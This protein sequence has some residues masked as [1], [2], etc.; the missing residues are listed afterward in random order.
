MV[1]VADKKVELYK[2]GP[3][4]SNKYQIESTARE[5]A[6]EINPDYVQSGELSIVLIYTQAKELKLPKRA[7]LLEKI[8]LPKEAGDIEL[9]GYKLKQDGY[10]IKVWIIKTP[11]EFQSQS[12]PVKTLLRDL[13]LN[14]LRVHLEK[15]TLRILL[16]GIRDIPLEIEKNSEEA[17]IVNGYFKNTS[18]KLF[19]KTRYDIAQK[20]LLDFALQSENTIDRGSFN[21]LKEEISLFQNKYIEQNLYKLTESMAK[22]VILCICANP[23]DKNP[24]EFDK[25]FKTLK[26]NHQG[27]LD[28]DHYE[29]EV[30]LSVEKKEFSDLLDRY[31]PE[32]LHLSLHASKKDGLYFEG[33]NRKIVPMPVD[34]FKSIISRYTQ[35][36]PLKLVLISACNSLSHADAIKDFCQ[37]AIGTM[38]V[39]PVPAALVY[40]DKFYTS[41]FNGS[42]KDIKYSHLGA[43]N[44]IRYNDPAFEDLDYG[45][46]KVPVYKI[47]I[48]I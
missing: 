46:K 26:K 7:F 24:I 38:A 36:Y 23:R 10:P 27:S 3:H 9:Y 33:K 39:F 30:E 41:L 4:L 17:N 34:E 20:N 14:L 19:R 11:P 8:A 16:N 22:K 18:E 25:E 21:Y 35:K 12:Q 45:D 28:R 29:I 43:I 42:D 2:A 47:P 32:Y 31:K 13:R 6:L 40:A 37:Y 5:H 44:A 1:K 48:L 15:E